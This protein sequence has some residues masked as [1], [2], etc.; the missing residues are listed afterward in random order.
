MA[1][2]IVK[3][4]VYVLVW[5]ALMCLTGATAWIARVDLA[6][7]NGVIA[8]IIAFTK[9]TLVVLFFMH[10]YFSSK[11]TKVVMLAAMLWFA[12]L[13]CI[14]MSDYLTRGWMSYPQQ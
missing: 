8:L 1:E 2:D 9:G 7:F 4:R 11:L 10:L 5:V 14:T 13:L 3:P 12:I 6:P